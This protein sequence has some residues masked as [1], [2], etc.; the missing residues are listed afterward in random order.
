MAR[1]RVVARKQTE[2]PTAAALS[3]ATN[4]RAP[5]LKSGFASIETVRRFSL[6]S[7]ITSR[8]TKS[9]GWMPSLRISSSSLA[10]SGPIRW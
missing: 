9:I 7:A 10:A 5:F 3:D 6:S 4:R 8:P 1:K 2:R